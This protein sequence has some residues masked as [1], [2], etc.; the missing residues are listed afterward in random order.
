[1]DENVAARGESLGGD[2]YIVGVR[3]LGSST[4]DQEGTATD[5]AAGSDAAADAAWATYKKPGET[6]PAPSAGAQP[7]QPAAEPSAPTA[8]ARVENIRPVRPPAG[9]EKVFLLHVASAEGSAF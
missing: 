8:A 6:T 4:S 7:A 5:Q 1:S 2:S 9:E 3:T